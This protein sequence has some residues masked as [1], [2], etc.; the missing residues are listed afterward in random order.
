MWRRRRK[1]GDPPSGEPEAIFSNLRGKVLDLD[2][3]SVGL[4][5]S[6]ELPRVWGGLME[7][8]L[9]SGVATIVSLAD[10]TTSMYTSTGGGV[11]GG[12]EHAHVAAASR[13]FLLAFEREL[14]LLSPAEEEDLPG[15]GAVCF[16]ALTY[17][18]RRAATAPDADLR[19]RDHPLKPL[20]MAGHD[21]I[22]A[23][24]TA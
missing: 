2:P 1:R 16:R 15:D 3:A 7:L 8:G 20:F 14:E 17:E 22:T 18:G 9:D 23:L 19:Q 5:P 10:G 12:G 11:I 13:A 24:R 6:H 4:A 21:V